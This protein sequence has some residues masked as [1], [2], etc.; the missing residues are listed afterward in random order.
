[1]ARRAVSRR[2]VNPFIFSPA[3]ERVPP[4]LFTRKPGILKGEIGPIAAD[5]CDMPEELIDLMEG[6]AE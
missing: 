4:P 6:K 3:G 2:R 5:A 1:L